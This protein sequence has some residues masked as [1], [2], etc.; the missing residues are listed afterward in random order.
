[1][2]LGAG[3]TLSLPNSMAQKWFYRRKHSGVAI[4]IVVSGVGIGALIFAR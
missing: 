4:A 2:S 1:M 3:I